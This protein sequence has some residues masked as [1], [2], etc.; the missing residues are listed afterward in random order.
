MENPKCPVFLSLEILYLMVEI[1]TTFLLP[2]Q[3]QITIRTGSTSRRAQPEDLPT[4]EL[5][6]T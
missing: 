6:L 1:T 2:L 4:V 5:Q 3:D